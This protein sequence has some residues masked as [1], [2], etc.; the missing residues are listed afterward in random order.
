MI[1]HTGLQNEVDDRLASFLYQKNASSRSFS[2]NSLQSS[3][4]NKTTVSD[5]AFYEKQEIPMQKSPVME[6]ILHRRSLQ[7]RSKQQDWQVCLP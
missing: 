4:S 2:D 5:G 3:T 6:R 1:L 7:L